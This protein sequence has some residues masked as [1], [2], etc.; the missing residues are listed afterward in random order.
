MTAEEIYIIKDFFKSCI[1]LDYSISL[2]KLY[3]LLDLWTCTL[4]IHFMT[5]PHNIILALTD[6]C[7]CYAPNNL[8]FRDIV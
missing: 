8:A 1:I 2:Y 7:C 5:C 4:I 3:Q 6:T